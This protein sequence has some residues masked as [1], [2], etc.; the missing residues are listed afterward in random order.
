[1]LW[2]G[3]VTIMYVLGYYMCVN[4]LYLDSLCVLSYAWPK[5]GLANQVTGLIS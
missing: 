5:I 4:F 1:M 3:W 2:A